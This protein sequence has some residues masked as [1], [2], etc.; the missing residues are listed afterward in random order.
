MMWIWFIFRLPTP[1]HNIGDSF[2]TG[3]NKTVKGTK[4]NWL[5]SVNNFLDFIEEKL[6]IKI[7]IAPHPKIEYSS[8]NLEIYNNRKVIKSEL[9]RSS[10]NAKL[11]ISRD[12]SGTAFAAMYKIPA[13]FIFTNEL[14]NLKNNFLD[15]QKKFA[16][17]FGLVPININEEISDEKLRQIMKF[18]YES[19]QNYINKYCS[20]RDDS[21]VNFEIISEILN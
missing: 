7:F 9:V 13:V 18:D 20:A 2:I 4:K 14:E 10:K 6:K 11:I 12:S 21:K 8:E 17:E 19:Y 16:N 3:D 5:K 15:H 1:A